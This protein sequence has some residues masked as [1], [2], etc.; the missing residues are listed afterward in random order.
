MGKRKLIWS[1]LAK[2]R[3]FEILDFY[4]HRN[5]SSDFSKKLYREFYQKLRLTINNPELGI[6]TDFDSIR[7]VIVRD[8]ILFYELSPD[9]IIVHTVWDTRQNPEKLKIK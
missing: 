9:H 3:L 2:I 4:T 1:H 5:K 7:G 8:F 6:K